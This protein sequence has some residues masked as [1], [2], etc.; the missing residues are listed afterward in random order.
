MK[1]G[2]SRVSAYLASLAFILLIM[3]IY[4]TFNK[5][6]INFSYFSPLNIIVFLV[7]YLV[8]NIILSIRIKILAKILGS[9]ISIKDSLYIRLFSNG[10]GTLLPVAGYDLGRIIYLTGS[11]RTGVNNAISITFIEAVFDT[12]VNSLFAL[13]FALLLA[14][15]FIISIW[16][17]ILSL[18]Q[19]AF[20]I[21]LSLYVS[22]SKIS[23]IKKEVDF[24]ERIPIIKNYVERYLSIRN[25]VASVFGKKTFILIGI[26]MSAFYI[27]LLSL[28]FSIILGIKYFVSVGIMA[29]SLEALTLPLPGGSGVSELFL[30]AFIAPSQVVI[31]RLYFVLVPIVLGMPLIA[32]INYNISFRDII[33]KMSGEGRDKN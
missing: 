5:I 9:Q 1:K 6:S 24:L 11:I 14:S 13:L 3:F 30:S 2:L 31:V 16:I 12:L 15:K 26:L 28:P 10:L 27:L 32:N 8:A 29:S 33:K 17:F 22:N 25:S 21:G 19:L 4:I 20:W 7:T 18:A 23:L